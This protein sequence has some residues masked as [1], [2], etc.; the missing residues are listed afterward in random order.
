MSPHFSCLLYMCT[1]CRCFKRYREPFLAYRNGVFPWTTLDHSTS[2]DS[3]ADFSA[4]SAAGDLYN[5]ELGIPRAKLKSSSSSRNM[6]DSN[7]EAQAAHL[8]NYLDEGLRIPRAH[9]NDT[10]SLGSGSSEYTIREEIE[11]RVI[12]DITTTEL[13]TT[14]ED[15]EE[16]EK[17][18][19]A[20]YESEFQTC[21]GGENEVVHSETVT[22]N[23]TSSA[24]TFGSQ[25]QSS[26]SHV[27]DTVKIDY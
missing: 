23:A 14:T 9:L 24:Q 22:K 21:R 2:S 4:M 16:Q 11:R 5:H 19:S 1:K 3:G 20:E 7:A 6:M 27:R 26:S 10:S 25:G 18:S 12:T 8:T 13:R 15:I 17:S